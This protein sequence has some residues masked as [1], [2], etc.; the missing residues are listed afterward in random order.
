MSSI[1]LKD[2]GNQDD[3]DDCGYQWKLMEPDGS[4][5]EVGEAVALLRFDAIVFCFLAPV[6]F[7]GVANWRL[8][9]GPI[10]AHDSIHL[11]KT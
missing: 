10:V 7:V 1:Y 8:G 4:I 6:L 5:A 3:G 9:A 11:C 2:F